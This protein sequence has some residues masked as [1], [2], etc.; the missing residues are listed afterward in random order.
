MDAL[1]ILPDFSG[2][3]FSRGHVRLSVA[4]P[5]GP[6]PPAGEEDVYDEFDCLQRTGK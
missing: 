2:G 6:T 1:V 3:P 4:F 5:F